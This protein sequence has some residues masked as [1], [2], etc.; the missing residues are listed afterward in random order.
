MYYDKRVMISKVDGGYI[1]ATDWARPIREELLVRENLGD[2]MDVIREYFVRLLDDQE[3]AMD[4]T[5]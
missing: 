1:V 2:A 4:K 5:K 3:E